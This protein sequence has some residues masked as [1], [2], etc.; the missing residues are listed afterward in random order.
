M[1][2]FDYLGLDG[3]A[4][5]TFI[6]VLEE[7]SVSKAASRLNVTQSA[8]SHTLDKLR[9][10]FHDPLFTRSGRGIMPTAKARSLREPIENILDEL[11]SLT[12]ERKFDPLT[13]PIEFTIAAND[14][15]RQL[16]FPKLLKE[17]YAEGINPRLRFIN[18]GTPKANLRRALRCQLLISPL[19]PEGK[20]LIKKELFQSKMVCFYDAEI[21]KPPKTLK[22]LTDSRYVNVQFSKTESSMLALPEIDHSSLNPPDIAVPNFSALPDFI[23]GTDLITMQLDTMRYGVLKGLA[24]SPL[25]LETQTLSMYMIWHQRDHDDPAHRWLR[26]R[27]IDT[28][29]SIAS[30]HGERSEG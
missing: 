6:T 17:L 3:S 22:E 18:S 30:H 16:I 29:N 24:S 20:D 26:K 13:E 11:K 10:A 2:K 9:S 1:N 21:R 7:E 15:Q 19:P 12:H 5:R 27:V 8:V 23:K 4:L 25:P 28:V 14:F